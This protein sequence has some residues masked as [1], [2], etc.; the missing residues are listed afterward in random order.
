MENSSLL[1]KPGIKNGIAYGVAMSI[2]W[3]VLY[4]I[5]WEL[6][7]APWKVVI[8]VGIMIFFI[9]TAMKAK[10][11]MKGGYIKFGDAVSAGLGTALV[12]SVILIITACL[13]HIVIDTELAENSKII[14]IERMEEAAGMFGGGSEEIMDKMM[15][16]AESLD[17]GINTRNVLSFIGTYVLCGL[18]ISLI[19]AIF[20]K[21]DPPLFEDEGPSVSDLAP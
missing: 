3:L 16:E 21:R 17:T 19:T 15:E 1:S 14:T 10:R 4:F 18:V 6:L 7:Y 9:A 12:G 20:I 5:N 2:I 8:T 13:L 11:A